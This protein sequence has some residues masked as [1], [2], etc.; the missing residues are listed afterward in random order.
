MQKTPIKY[1]RFFMYNFIMYIILASAS[2]RR[3][4]ILS[5]AGYIL[6]VIPSSYD[7]K[8]SNLNYK[9]SL[10]EN[11]AIQKVL[12]VKN[13]IKT[14]NLIVSADTVVVL[15]DKILGKPKD[16]EDAYNM[17]SNLSNK[18]HF[19]ATSI[20]LIKSD[21]IV[22]DSEITYVTFRR[23]SDEDIK[24]YIK[25]NKPFDKAGSYGIQ[26]KG[27]DFVESVAGNIDNVI[28]FP[29][30]LFELCYH[31]ILDD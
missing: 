16:F 29:V 3:K 28:G 22:A 11:C 23:L 26:D 12:D 15:N 9:Q 6:D 7:E 17:L 10:V 5:K 2:P 14:N 20:C 31:K 30:S 1:R 8:I 18:T 27:F 25:T 13:K 24:K 21:R 4:E 19:V